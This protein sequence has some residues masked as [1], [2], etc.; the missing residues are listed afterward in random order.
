MTEPLR[1]PTFAETVKALR[2]TDSTYPWVQPTAEELDVAE[3]LEEIERLH[4][5]GDEPDFPDEPLTPWGTCSECGTSWP[6]ERW[7]WAHN[8]AV[9]FLTRGASRYL[10]RVNDAMARSDARKKG[11]A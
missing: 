11:A 3:V 5:G 8:L 1:R 6:C 2:I 4:Q 7:G 9:Q 10:N